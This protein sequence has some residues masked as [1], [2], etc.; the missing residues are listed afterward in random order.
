MEAVNSGLKPGFLWDIKAVT[1]DHTQ[2][3]S[4]VTDLKN[5]RLLHSGIYVVS[6]GDELIVAN[7]RHV[8]V[9]CSSNSSSY[10]VDV[11]PQ[12]DAPCTVQEDT[13]IASDIHCML[14]DVSKLIAE[15]L[16][17]ETDNKKPNESINESNS[18]AMKCKLVS[19]PCISSSCKRIDK[20]KV[21]ITN[22]IDT[23]E[24]GLGNLCLSD[25]EDRDQRL[26]LE[27]L[28]E[29]GTSVTKTGVSKTSVNLV[30]DLKSENKRHFILKTDENW[31]V[32]TL[33]GVFLGYPVVYW[34][35]PMSI[36]NDGETC[37]SFVPLT[38]FKINVEICGRY[39]NQNRCHNLY[40]FS[41]P[42]DALPYLEHKVRQWFKDLMDIA[43]SQTGHFKNIRLM[44]E[45]VVLPSV[46]L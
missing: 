25:K 39:L 46:V 6:I 8:F 23:S 20:R 22:I 9:S 19:E 35:K 2:L 32:P 13:D 44:K 30:Q 10:F 29:L 41:V 16:G 31:C 3:L 42:S 24:T 33:L 40:S 21:N 14:E 12:L 27:C 17:I 45:F 26:N 5:S 38:V 7:L 15:F 4:L 11:S 36:R 43:K 34:F 18:E 1:M 37:L 28:K